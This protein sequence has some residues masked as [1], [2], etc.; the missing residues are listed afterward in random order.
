[1]IVT[2]LLA[3]YEYAFSEEG[4]GVDGRWKD[5]IVSIVRASL[6]LGEEGNLALLTLDEPY[7]S[8]V[9]VDI[10]SEPALPGQVPAAC[11]SDDHM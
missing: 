5:V 1:M 11:T 10:A 4:G 3:L 2:V 6:V 8:L 9:K 7:R